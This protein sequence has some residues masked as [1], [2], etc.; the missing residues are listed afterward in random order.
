MMRVTRRRLGRPM[1]SGNPV[2]ERLYTVTLSGYQWRNLCAAA[3]ALAKKKQRED[4]KL[5]FIP[6]PG[7]RNMSLTV[8]D[9]LNAAAKAIEHAMAVERIGSNQYP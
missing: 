8:A 2:L 4:A 6:A 7:K 1:D 3:R 9:D 5:H